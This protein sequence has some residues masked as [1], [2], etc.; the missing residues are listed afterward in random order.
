MA[1]AFDGIRIVDLTTMISGPMA[2]MVMADQGAEVI[3]V[4][5]LAGDQVRA[6]G[7]RHNGMTG[8]FFSC[9]RGKKSVA[10]DLKTEDGKAVLWDL[11]ASAD[12]LVQNFRPGAIDRMGFGEEAVRKAKP[13][14]LYVSISG[15][16][17]KGPYAHKRVYDPVIQ[18]L[19]GSTDV[20]ADRQTGRPQMFQ[21][22]IA[23]KVTALTAAQAISAGLFARER[24]G[25]GQHIK[26][27]MLDSLIAFFWAEQM[28]TLNFVGHEADPAT[29]RSGMDLIYETEDGFITAGAVSDK[30]WRGLCT[31]LGKP[32][33]IEDP[34][35]KEAGPRMKSVGVRKE[36]TAAEIAKWKSADILWRLD[37]ADVPS[38][39]LLKRIDLLEDEQV[40]ANEL[41]VV[42]EYGD[43]GPVRQPRPAAR[44]DGTPSAIRGA[45]PKLG[46]HAG[47]VLGGLGYSE[48]KIAGLRGAGV[49]GG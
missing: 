15:F 39:P 27:S 42:D 21:V 44:F 18:A 3:K 8:A 12:A 36:L 19:T 48:E 49:L 26:L 24:T 28:P 4:E 45:A 13:D 22:I 38:A 1:G 47:E 25:E 23:D 10:V 14:I 33:W 29:F 41:L 9:N 30:E 35:F 43:L 31:V 7:P 20:Q 46:E 17:E 34:R 40:K 37:E 6:L 5:S 32:E 2:C 16:G 11:I